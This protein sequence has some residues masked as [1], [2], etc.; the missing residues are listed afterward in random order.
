MG[1]GASGFM[2]DSEFSM[3]VRKAGFRMIYAPQIVVWHKLPAERLTP[4][5]FLRRYFGWGRS[6][7]YLCPLPTALW[8]FG[9]YALKEF[10]LSEGTELRRRLTFHS[11]SSVDLARRC[12]ARHAL[13]FSWQHWLLKRG[14]QLTSLGHE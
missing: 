1:A 13:G 11:A 6:Q 14:A 9:C 8:R 2:E 5:F 4:S 12:K 7:A 10:A 3:R